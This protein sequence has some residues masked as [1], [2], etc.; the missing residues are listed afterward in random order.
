MQITPTSA[1]K[2]AVIHGPNLNLLGLREPDI[3]GADTFDDVNRKIEERARQLGLEIRIRQTNHEGEI[4]D[5]IHDAVNWADGIVI[6]PG[7]YTHYAYAIAD[8]IR[9]VRLPV[10]EVHLTN[11]H[12]R[13]EWRHKSVISPATVGQIVGFGAESYALGLQALRAVL[14]QGRS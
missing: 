14:L 6:N 4:I 5:I 8:A 12:A 1:L 7:A 2:I 13:E 10:V 11:V 9:G 3:Y